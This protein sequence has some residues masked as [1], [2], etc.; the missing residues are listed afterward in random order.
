MISLNRSACAWALRWL[1]FAGLLG[2]LAFAG[3]KPSAPPTSSEPP[4]ATDKN[5]ESKEEPKPPPAADLALIPPSLKTD[6][7]EFYGLGNTEALRYE[8]IADGAAPKVGDQTVRFTGMKDGNAQFSIERTGDL[9]SAMGSQ[10]LELRPKG[11]YTT[12]T[13]LGSI[14]GDSLELP[15]SLKI[16]T[17]WKADQ[18]LKTADERQV[19]SSATYKVVR[20]EKVKTKG[21]DFDA[22]LVTG[23]GSI[24]LDGQKA[25]LD[26]KQWLAKGKGA[27]KTE[28]ATKFESGTGT[29]VSIELNK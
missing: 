3:C 26:M 14:E 24:T 12:Q 17:T 20:M 4:K 5:E 11:I 19:K 22:L 7:F 18:S 27:V 25:S 8:V 15:S 21:G 29:K 9:A 16:G 28:I 2:S 13:S 10:E 23:K 1:F 6:A